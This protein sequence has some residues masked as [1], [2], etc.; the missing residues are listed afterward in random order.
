MDILAHQR[1]VKYVVQLLLDE[2][3][4]GYLGRKP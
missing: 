1:T 4:F 3:T 2:S